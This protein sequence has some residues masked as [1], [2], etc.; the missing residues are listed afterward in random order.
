MT[1]TA[2]ASGIEKGLSK[3]KVVQEVKVNFALER[4]TIFYEPDKT[5]VNEYKEKIDKL[6][7][8]VV[9]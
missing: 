5:N 8:H 4:S 6:G 1:C 9:I 7:Y 2:C 3:I